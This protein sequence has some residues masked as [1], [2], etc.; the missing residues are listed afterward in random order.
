MISRLMREPRIPS[1]PIDM[2]SD[3]VM[4]PNSKG[5][6][7]EARTPTLISSTSGLDA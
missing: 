3:T 5:E 7:P 6:P 4:V 2:A 1:V